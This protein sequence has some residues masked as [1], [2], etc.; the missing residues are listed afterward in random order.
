MP[1]FFINTDILRIVLHTKF[2]LAGSTV[3]RIN[4]VKPDNSTGFFPATIDGQNLTYQILAGD[5]DQAGTW[6]F[7]AYIVKAGK[8][9]RGKIRTKTFLTPI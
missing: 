5:I 3:T 2:D 9:G 7:Q 8:I 6:K 1:D 4:Y